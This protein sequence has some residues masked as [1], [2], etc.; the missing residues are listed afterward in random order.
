VRHGD[1]DVAGIVAPRRGNLFA[2]RAHDAGMSERIPRGTGRLGGLAISV[3]LATSVALTVAAACSGSASPQPVGPVAAHS[4]IDAAPM[5]V[6]DRDPDDEDHVLPIDQPRGKVVVTTSDACGM[7]IDSV[8]FPQ[9]SDTPVSAGAID[10][11]ADMLICMNKES[12]LLL[13]L[14]VQAYADPSERDSDELTVRRAQTVATML[15]AR[16]MP[17]LGPLELIPYGARDLRDKSGTADG[18][19]RNRRVDFLILER[20]T[21]DN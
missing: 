6:E 4:A 7:M 1:G 17:T 13:R 18:R 15:T 16:K 3:A 8:Y 2:M 9:N 19:A 11:I 14:A 21:N 12:G 10:G 20:K 5:P